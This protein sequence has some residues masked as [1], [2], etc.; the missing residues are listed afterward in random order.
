MRKAFPKEEWIAW[1]LIGVG[2]RARTWDTMICLCVFKQFVR[3]NGLLFLSFFPFF[4]VCVFYS[5]PSNASNWIKRIS[6]ALHFHRGLVPGLPLTTKNPKLLKFLTHVC[7]MRAYVSLLL[8][9]TD[10]TTLGRLLCGCLKPSSSSYDS[11]VQ[12]SNKDQQAA[13]PRSTC[14]AKPSGFQVR[15]TPLW[16]AQTLTKHAG[17]I[18]R[19]NLVFLRNK[20]HFL[21]GVRDILDPEVTS[22][23]QEKALMLGVLINLK[24][25]QNGQR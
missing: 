9:L 13:L 19:R 12:S 20:P 11:H 3:K 14:Q 2:V 18:S 8:D 7:P 25:T 1:S 16:L 6:P 5:S 21:W 17:A 15:K 22:T 4:S 24:S 10:I 23:L